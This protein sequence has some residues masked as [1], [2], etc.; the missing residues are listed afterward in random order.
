MLQKYID[1]NK[2]VHKFLSVARQEYGS[3]GRM[4]WFIYLECGNCGHKSSMRSDVAIKSTKCDNCSRRLKNLKHGLR[5]KRIYHVWAEMLARTTR[6]THRKYNRYGGRG[7]IVEFKNLLEFYEWSLLN[8][9]K[10]VQ[11]GEYKDYLAIDRIDNN[12][13]YSV[14]NCQWITVS[15]NSSKKTGPY[16]A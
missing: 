9:Y 14:D 2:G 11:E 13:N 5:G 4:G 1:K 12:G 7:I 15:E 10:E 16:K 8:G 6:D 3:Q